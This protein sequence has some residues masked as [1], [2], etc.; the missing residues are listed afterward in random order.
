MLKKHVRS[1]SGQSQLSGHLGL[2]F[3]VVGCVITLGLLR[4]MLSGLVQRRVVLK[5]SVKQHN[6]FVLEKPVEVG[7]AVG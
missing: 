5:K 3:G 4:L 1:G 7:I 6:A 2:G